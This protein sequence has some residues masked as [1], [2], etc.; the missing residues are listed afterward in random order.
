[1]EVQQRESLLLPEC[2]CRSGSFQKI[3]RVCCLTTR[4]TRVSLK[5]M[6]YRTDNRTGKYASSILRTYMHG[7]LFDSLAPWNL[8][9][10]EPNSFFLNMERMQ[11]PHEARYS[12]NSPDNNKAFFTAKGSLFYYT[13]AST[14]SAFKLALEQPHIWPLIYFSAQDS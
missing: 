6:Q 11:R 1:M 9:G 4:T 7:E 12:I 5:A 13:S 10:S 8:T 14:T 3:F 2:R